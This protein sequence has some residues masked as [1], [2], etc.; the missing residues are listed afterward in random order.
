MGNFIARTRTLLVLIAIHAMVVGS[1]VAQTDV[2]IFGG[3]AGW[4]PR[5]DTEYDASYT[6]SR[7]GGIDDLFVEPDPRSAA[8]QRLALRGGTSFGIGLGL[9]VYPHDLLGFQFLWDRASVDIAGRNAPHEV[10]LVFDS[11]SFPE[12]TPIE[13]ISEF[14]FEW[15]DTVG[16]LDETTLSFNLAA[17]FDTS[18]VVSAALRLGRALRAAL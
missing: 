2:E 7:V 12:P 9:S 17:R 4:W 6:P 5:L 10:T 16:T 15:P 13:V 18:R 14:A 3:I 1:A 8:R 11:L